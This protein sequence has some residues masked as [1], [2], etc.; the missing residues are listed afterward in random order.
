MT[1]S[2]QNI[3]QNNLPLGYTGSIGY[4]GS[5]G[6]GYTG[7]ASPG[8]TGSAGIPG[9]YAGLGYTGSGGLGYTG[10]A[11]GFTGSVGYTGSPGVPGLF[12]GMGYTGS[13]G[14]GY[15]GSTGGFN[16]VQPINVQT[17]TTYSLQLS[18]VGSVIE[19]YNV[20]PIT[21]TIPPDTA[22]GVSVGQ[23]IDVVQASLG[24]VFFVG[25]LNV[26]INVSGGVNYLN[27]LWSGAS[28]LKT[29][30]NEWLLITP[31]PTGFTGSSG[32]GYV[33]SQGQ[34]FSG[35]VGGFN[36]VQPINIQTGTSYSIQT[37]DAGNLIEFFN[38]SPITLTIPPDS[39][40]NFTVGQRI[41]VIQRGAGAVFF[42]GGP[43]ITLI[44]PDVNYLNV[45]NVA[46]TLMKTAAY[47]WTLITPSTVGYTGSTGSGFV[48]SGGGPG[49]SGSA[50]GFASAQTVVAVLKNCT[51]SPASLNCR[52]YVVPVT[53][54]ISCA[55]ANPPRLPE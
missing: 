27:Q 26:V 19:L 15:A 47:E 4:T 10:S 48:G 17:G 36:A 49:Y 50:G 21:V 51:R 5:S 32:A 35:S 41:D 12:A 22:L 20:A 46:A 23:R 16:S 52:V 54:P 29:G 30:A 14:A 6:A 39:N 13:G 42:V 9:Q 8:Y 45:T 31:S 1:I 40:L 25:G 7:S 44:T 55:L 34:G 37:S 43:G 28:L 11:S 33:G 24:S 18:D 38:S 2:I 53:I 3:L